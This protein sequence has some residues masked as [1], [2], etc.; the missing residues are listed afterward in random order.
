MLAAYDYP[1]A[2][3]ID[4]AGLDIILVGDSLGMAFQGQESTIPVTVDDIVYHTRTAVR[5][6]P[7]THV[8]ADLPF[9]SYQQSDAQALANAG[10]LMQEG[11]ANSV[12]LEGGV[13]VADRVRALVSAGIP[14]CAHIGLTPQS[15]GVTG[16]Y[17]VQGRDLG[18]ANQVLADAE[19]V[20]EAGAYAVVL[21]MVPA[22]VAAVITERLAIPTI[23]IGAGVD[24]DG[25]VLV[26]SD[27]IGLDDR[28]AFKFVR[29][30]AEVGTIMAEAFRA[31]AA[32]VRQGAFPGPEETYRLKPAVAA[33][34]RDE[35]EAGAGRA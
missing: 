33:A 9:L 4:G 10:R 21:E 5:G 34:L 1:T 16:G 3:L 13:P 14:V 25:Q 6:A 30:Y 31:F 8:V 24:C 7:R 23:G 2:R 19:A 11:G 17:R 22:E 15:V 29:R 18:S 32:D 26:A 28:Y 27:L 35:T 20:A 12:K